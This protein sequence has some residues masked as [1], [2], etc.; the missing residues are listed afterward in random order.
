MLLGRSIEA[1]GYPIFSMTS[2]AGHDAAIMAHLTPIAMLFVRC[3]AGISHNPLES[4]TV[5][6]VASALA[7]LEHF[8]LLLSQERG[9]A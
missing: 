1:Q 5:E 3:R 7:A 6:D 9:T 8:V 4:V 2:G